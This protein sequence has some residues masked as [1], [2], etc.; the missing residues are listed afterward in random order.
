MIK[1]GLTG[2]IASGKSTVEEML[3]KSYKVV[4]LDKISHEFIETKCKDEIL[5]A[6][7]TTNRKELSKIVFKDKN[8]LKKL[9][10]IIHPKLREYVT[11]YFKN[12]KNEKIVFISGA[13]IY[14]VGF[15]DLFDKII[16]VD[17]NKDLRL[18]RLMKRNSLDEQTALVRINAQN[19]NYKNSADYIIENNSNIEDLEEKLLNVL[20]NIISP[21]A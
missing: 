19:E 10:N 7:N 8:E 15:N 9:E 17:A 2:N 14:E 21:N 20:D 11:E 4:D 3:S 5:K 16:F 12:N 1:I 13:L 18:H 6:F